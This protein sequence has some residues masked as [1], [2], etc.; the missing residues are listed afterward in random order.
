MVGTRRVQELL[1][2]NLAKL[3]GSCPLGL[4]APL[5]EAGLNSM[6][7]LLLRRSLH[8]ELAFRLPLS[9]VSALPNLRSMIEHILDV[10]KKEETAQCFVKT[11]V[12][13]L[14]ETLLPVSVSVCEHRS[15]IEMIPDLLEIKI[16]VVSQE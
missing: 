15:G 1:E 10:E 3:L 12:L 6:S 8:S 7:A 2:R 5:V 14:A 9:F 16:I 11:G 13:F 4:D